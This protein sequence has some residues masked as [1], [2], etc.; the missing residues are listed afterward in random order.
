[1]ARAA[2]EQDVTRALAQNV[3][4]QGGVSGAV[5]SMPSSPAEL[6]QCVLRGGAEDELRRQHEVAVA[7]RDKFRVAE[8]DRCAAKPGRGMSDRCGGQAQGTSG[9]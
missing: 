2:V 1:M 6:R 9:A 5:G 7:Q 4:L 8:A 3:T